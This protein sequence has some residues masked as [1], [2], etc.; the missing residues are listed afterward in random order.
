[1]AKQE[2]PKGLADRW[3]ALVDEA[4]KRLFAK[5][6]EIQRAVGDRPYRGLPMGEDEMFARWLQ[7]R[8]DTE[9]LVEL[10]SQNSIAKPDG[11]VLVPRKMVEAMV[12]QEKRAR[13][14]GYDL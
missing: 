8:R 7:I 12:K 4:S 1:M 10:L 2:V 3:E 5:R 14:G 11:H 6:K 9:S 13:R